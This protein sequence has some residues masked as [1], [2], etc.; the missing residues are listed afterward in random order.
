MKVATASSRLSAAIVRMLTIAAVEKCAIAS[1][2]A[3]KPIAGRQRS[4]QNIRSFASNE[5]RSVFGLA[6]FFLLGLNAIFFHPPVQRPAAQAGGFCGLA[7]V[8]VGRRE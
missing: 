7:H 1:S 3:R 2:P 6:F 4:A 5:S 8:P